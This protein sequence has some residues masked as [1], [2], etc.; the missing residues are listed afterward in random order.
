MVLLERWIEGTVALLSVVYSVLVFAASREARKVTREEA[1]I[2]GSAVYFPILYCLPES[3]DVSG[4][5]ITANTSDSRKFN[6]AVSLA[7]YPYP[8]THPQVICH[9]PV[10]C[11][12]PRFLVTGVVLSVGL[13]SLST[14]VYLIVNGRVYFGR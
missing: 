1:E 12:T 7:V 11:P 5:Q 10:N 13:S 6:L 9:R 8:I 4:Q 3:L 14:L 2:D